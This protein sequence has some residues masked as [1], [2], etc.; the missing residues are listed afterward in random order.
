M[1]VHGKI[2]DAQCEVAQNLG[3]GDLV[4][5]ESS[6]DG[7]L[8]SEVQLEAH[9]IHEVQATQKRNGGVQD[10]D[11]KNTH[12]LVDADRKECQGLGYQWFASTKLET[13]TLG[14]K[15]CM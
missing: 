13:F 15:Y 7:C 6:N 2:C 9:L 10:V 14:V 5:V 1:G 12:A 4:V 11:P 3:E 8:V